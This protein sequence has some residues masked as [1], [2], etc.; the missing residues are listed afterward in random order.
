[1]TSNDSLH[2]LR[3]PLFGYPHQVCKPL[4]IPVVVGLTWK[5]LFPTPFLITN[6]SCQEFPLY[7]L[8]AC[9]DLKSI[10]SCIAG[11]RVEEPGISL[12]REVPHRTCIN[13]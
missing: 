8:W 7:S 9:G 6:L 3:K 5:P 12:D 10:P 4:Y 1:M 2:T 13:L 11:A